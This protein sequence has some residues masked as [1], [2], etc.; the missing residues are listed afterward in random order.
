MNLLPVG[1]DALLVEVEDVH[2]ATAL[3]AEARRLRLAAGDVVPAARTVLFTDVPDVPELARQVEGLSLEPGRLGP[4]RDEPGPLL[5]VPTTYDGPDLEVVARAWDMSTDEVVATHTSHDQVVAFCGFAP[6]FAYCT[7]LPER[8]A[9]ARL[10]TPR[11]RVPAGSVGLAGPFTG[12]YPSESPGGWQLIG[13]TALTLWDE[14]RDRPATLTPG[15]R[16][17]FVEVAP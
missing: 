12:V 4:G 13:R 17:R 9:V 10:D 7:G 16:V 2:A 11:S 3:Y 1:A 8:L 15:T 5:E 14:A 6:G